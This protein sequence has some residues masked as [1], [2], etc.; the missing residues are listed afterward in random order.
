MD[1]RGALQEVSELYRCSKDASDEEEYV[2]DLLR[3]PR[4]IICSIIYSSFIKLS[5]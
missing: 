4:S 5:E 1:Y 3:Q 2:H